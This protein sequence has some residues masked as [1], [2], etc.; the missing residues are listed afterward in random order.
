[1]LNTP[2]TITGLLIP[3]LLALSACA[4]GSSTADGGNDAHASNGQQFNQADV[5][6]A[7]RMIPHHEEAVRMARIAQARASSPQVQRLAEDIQAAQAPEITMMTGWLKSWG[8]APT[9]G[10]SDDMNGHEMSGHDMSGDMGDRRGG[11]MMG[12]Q[13]M[14]AMMKPSGPAFDR[15]F[16]TMMI[17]H[18][19]GAIDMARAEQARGTYPA[20]VAL[21]RKIEKTQTAEIARMQ[22]MLGS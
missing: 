5:A 9:S 19:E 10:M 13:R 7:Q 20:A 8:K 3:L 4:G 18:H 2:R 6:F 11:T 22:Q 15:M 17:E 16:L 1:M 14:R 21:A 12:E